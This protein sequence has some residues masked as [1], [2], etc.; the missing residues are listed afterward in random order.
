MPDSHKWF[1]LFQ[2]Y[3]VLYCQNFWSQTKTESLQSSSRLNQSPKPLLCVCQGAEYLKKGHS[4]ERRLNLED[5]FHSLIFN[6]QKVQTR[7]EKERM[8][9]CTSLQPCCQYFQSCAAQ[10]GGCQLC[11]VTE[12]MKW[13]WPKLRCNVNIKYTLTLKDL[14]EKNFYKV[15][16]CKQQDSTVYRRELYSTSYDKP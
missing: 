8:E 9:I 10:Q 15:S 6:F 11:V 1:L 16:H 7:K 3:K 4:I 2:N 13:I 14:W 5:A 12:D